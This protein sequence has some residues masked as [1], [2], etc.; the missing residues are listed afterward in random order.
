MLKH[1]GFAAADDPG[2]RSE[3]LDERIIK[4]FIERHHAFL[5]QYQPS[6]GAGEK[7]QTRIN[8]GHGLP[9]LAS[10]MS[11]AIAT[12]PSALPAASRQ[13][14]RRIASASAPH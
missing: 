9:P 4:R 6:T 3:S 2:D 1:F 11:S 7:R 10:K 8:G 14:A 13:S 12:G 5:D